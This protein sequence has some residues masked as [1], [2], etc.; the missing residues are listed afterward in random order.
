MCSDPDGVLAFGGTGKY[1]ASGSRGQIT[2]WDAQTY[3]KV[4]EYYMGNI[5]GIAFDESAKYLVSG[6]TS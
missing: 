5:Q 3:L 4:G 1:I 2:L 6:T